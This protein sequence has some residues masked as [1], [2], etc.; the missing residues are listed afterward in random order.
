MTTQS[1]LLAGQFHGRRGLVGYGPWSDNNEIITKVS[2]LV[3]ALKGKKAW[4]RAHPR[5]SLLVASHLAVQSRRMVC[6]AMVPRGKLPLVSRG[7]QG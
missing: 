3:S 1:S 6:G 4:I 7:N 2:K 5:L